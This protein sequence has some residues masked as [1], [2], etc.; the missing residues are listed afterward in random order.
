[1]VTGSRASIICMVFKHS[2]TNYC[3]TRLYPSPPPSLFRPYFSA[4]GGG[5]GHC[6]RCGLRIVCLFAHGTGPRTPPPP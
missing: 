3:T 2:C 5:G 4:Y 6:A 1:M